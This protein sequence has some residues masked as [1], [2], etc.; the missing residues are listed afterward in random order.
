MNTTTLPTFTGSQLLDALRTTQHEVKVLS[1]AGEFERR[2]DPAEAL[3]L[4]AMGSYEGGGRNQ[5]VRYLRLVDT[6][7]P[8][9]HD[10]AYWDRRSC[11]HYDGAP[12]RHTVDLWDRILQRA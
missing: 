9:V 6:R 2:V 8:N 5:R 10:A 4:A 12:D 7:T 3:H 11:R 1:V